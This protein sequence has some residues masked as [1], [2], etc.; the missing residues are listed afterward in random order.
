[1]LGARSNASARR[2]THAVHQ[3]TTAIAEPNGVQRTAVGLRLQGHRTALRRVERD[4][5][6][7]GFAEPGR[8][9]SLAQRAELAHE[10]WSRA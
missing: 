2:T 4:V 6:V 10:R 5:G 9:S 8:Q 7:T 1:M 3:T